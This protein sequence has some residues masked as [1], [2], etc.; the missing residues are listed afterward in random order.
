MIFSKSSGNFFSQKFG[1]HDFKFYLCRYFKI[2]MY[3]NLEDRKI[4]NSRILNM[5]AQRVSAYGIMARYLLTQASEDFLRSSDFKF[6]VD[7]VC[8]IASICNGNWYSIHIVYILN[9]KCE[10]I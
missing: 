1:R 4:R 5:A 10:S 7:D 9:Y 8:M 6:R 2:S 3:F